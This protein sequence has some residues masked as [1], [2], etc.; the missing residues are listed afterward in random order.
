MK[1]LLPSTARADCIRDKVRVEIGQTD[2]NVLQN[3]RLHITGKGTS[4]VRNLKGQKRYLESTLSSES[5]LWTLC[6]L[7]L[8]W[9]PKLELGHCPESYHC[10]SATFL[11]IKAQVIDVYISHT[12]SGSPDSYVSHVLFKLTKTTIQEL[13]DYYEN[14]HLPN[15]ALRYNLSES[16]QEVARTEYRQSL[17]DFTFFSTIDVLMGIEVDGSGELPGDWCAFAN[18]RILELLHRPTSRFVQDRSKYLLGVPTNG[19][20]SSTYHHYQL[21]HDQH[22]PAMMQDISLSSPSVQFMPNTLEY[23][24]TKPQLYYEMDPIVTNVSS[25]SAFPEVDQSSTTYSNSQTFPVLHG[26]PWPS[27]IAEQLPRRMSEVHTTALTP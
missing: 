7:M 8:P 2:Y 10:N 22:A 23:W 26:L 25:M 20:E 11:T 5:A 4:N 9:D 24:Y 1:T 15:T 6:Y 3:I 13:I 16:K 27:L 18:Y 12:A 17:A 14:I 21:S 19:M